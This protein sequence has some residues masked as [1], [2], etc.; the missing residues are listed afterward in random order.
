MEI[1]KTN[2]A[3][4]DNSFYNPGKNVLVRLIWYFCNALFMKGAIPGSSWRTGL[5][6]LF[7]AKIGK[8]VVIKPCVNIKY[9]WHLEVGEYTW[10]GEKVWIDNLGKVSIGKNCCISQGALLIC[11]NHN[12]KKQTFDLMV[13]EIVLE[14]G[15]WIGAKAL[16]AG[17]SICKSH[18]VL[19]AGSVASK[20]LEPFSI[21]S[22]NPSVK[23]KDRIIE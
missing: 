18:A 19:T 21:Y 14:D 16:V 7:G 22:G 13:G 9:P 4:Y 17:G 23:I 10:I 11:G 6:K 1:T 15:V 12:Y 20:V 8:N 3:N 2:L 5:L